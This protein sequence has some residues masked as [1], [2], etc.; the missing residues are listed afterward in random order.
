MTSTSSAPGS[1][2]LRLIAPGTQLVNLDVP[3]GEVPTGYLASLPAGNPDL[4]LVNYNHF[5]LSSPDAQSP[6]TGFIAGT[7]TSFQIQLSDDIVA[8]VNEQVALAVTPFAGGQTLLSPGVGVLDLKLAAREQLS[9]SRRR[10]H[11]EGS[12]LYLQGDRHQHHRQGA[13][14]GCHADCRSLIPG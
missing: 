9:A 3:E 7:P 1:S 8:H 4:L 5:N 12:D 13:V 6:I 14:D 2:R 11:S 10:L